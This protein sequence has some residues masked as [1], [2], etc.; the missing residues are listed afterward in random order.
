MAHGLLTNP[1]TEKVP[2]A[3]K[4]HTARWQC[5]ATQMRGSTLALVCVAGAAC[6]LLGAWLTVA[7]R[8]LRDRMRGRA[9]VARGKRGERDAERILTAAGY[10][11]VG[12]QVPTSY[13]IAVDGA[14][15]QV[16]LTLDFI[17]ERGGEELVAEVKTR[18]DGDAQIGRANT[19]R[20][21]LE[22]QL[23]TGT[24]RVLLV[25]PEAQRV[26]EVRFPL[27]NRPA[28]APSAWRVLAIF[29]VLAALVLWRWRSL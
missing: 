22:Y 12:R 1:R 28:R 11:I 16:E 9:S 17:V 26:S 14:A 10:R 23:A 3:E 24:G 25:E 5:D 8:R 15:Q 21:L 4:L 7:L 27:L 18:A 13:E 29:I 19:R 20:Q 2:H 6:V